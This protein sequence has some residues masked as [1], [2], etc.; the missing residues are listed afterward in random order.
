MQDQQYYPDGVA[1]VIKLLK[2]TF[3]DTFR[4]YFDGEPEIIPESLYPCIMVTSPSIRIATDSSA[5]DGLQEVVT[6]IMSVNRKDFLGASSDADMAEYWLRKRIIGQDPS[7]SQYLPDTVMYAIRQN[8]TL[9]DA[10]IGN[11][12]AVDFGQQERAFNR[13]GERTS[14]QEAYI[15]LDIERLALVPTRV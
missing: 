3:G 10:A 12:V 8:V 15:E 11:E 14:T 1:R 9:D 4:A 13:E 2:N 5:T 7:T 6:I